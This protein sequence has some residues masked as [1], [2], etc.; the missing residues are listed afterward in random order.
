MKKIVTLSL[1]LSLFIPNLYANQKQLPPPKVDVYEVEAPKDLQIES[2]Y[3]AVIEPV[4]QVEV[5]SRVSGLLMDKKFNEGD[6]VKKG[7][8]LFKVE[9]TI[10]KAKYEAAQANLSMAEALYNNA[11]K[12]YKRIEKLY[13]KKSI[14]EE[15]RDSAL[16]S[17]EDAKAK[18]A[19][20]QANLQQAKVDYEYTNIKAPISGFTGLK[21]VDIGEYVTGT[22]PTPLVTITQNNKLYVSFS[23]PASDYEKINNKIWVTKNNKEILVNII[24][25]GQDTKKVAKIDFIDVKIDRTTSSVKVRA[26]IDNED[27]KLSSGNFIKVK[28][29]NLIQKNVM[30]IPQ[31]AL[32]QSAKG[33]I[34]F[35]A[36]DGKAQVRPVMIG[37]E[38]GDKYTLTW[39]KLA[40]GDKV[41]INNFF[42]AK[43]MQAISVDTIINKQEEAK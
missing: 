33:T 7:A 12:D 1:L 40:P 17:Y 14:S 28:F 3:P 19:L 31:K 39:S 26:L 5:V 37:D 32:L 13:A 2:S 16:F 34:V 30:M 29:A 24:V 18:I 36:L 6:F 9:D 38:V 35:V 25:N 21:K 10:Y 42:R 22:P 20:A 43:P 11:S 8:F 4:A 15:K 27:G 41:I 23:I